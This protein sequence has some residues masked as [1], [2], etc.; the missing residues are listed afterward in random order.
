MDPP[1][2]NPS[3]GGNTGR[4]SGRGWWL[5]LIVAVVL[6][7]AAVGGVVFYLSLPK[8]NKPPV[9]TIQASDLSPATY[10]RVTLNGSASYDPDGGPLLFAWTLPGGVTSTA[11]IVNF[12]LTTVG[13]FRANLTVTDTG[14]AKNST[15]VRLTTHPATLRV[16]TNAPFPPFEFYDSNS[17]LVG[18]D[19]DL[20]DAL[21]LRLTYAPAWTDYADFTVLLASVGSGSV[22][23]GA[24]AITSSGAVGAQRNLTM[25]FSIP[26]YLVTFGVLVPSSSNLTCTASACTPANL[27]NRTVGVVA[28]TSEEAWVQ[29]NLVTSGVTPPSYVLTYTSTTTLVSAVSTGSVSMGIL[30]AHAAVAAAN[31]TSLRVAGLVAT[32]EQYSL[33]FPKTAAGLALRDRVNGVLQAMALDGGLQAL[34]SK[35]FAP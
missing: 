30:D 24:S 34:Y 7:A 31:G 27:A 8:A 6:V 28:G 25:Y 14:G 20:A 16:G 32:G 1:P 5:V 12:T 23:M 3:S 29:A 19:I 26:Y 17:N 22:D 18:F 4:A 10:E 15:S 21:S 11:T 9:A 33:A 13:T 35:W 2:A